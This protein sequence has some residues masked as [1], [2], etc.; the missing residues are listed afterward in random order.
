MADDVQRFQNP[1]S[2]FEIQRK[3]YCIFG[4]ER[5]F[6]SKSPE[7]FSAVFKQVGLR[8][9][10]VPFMSRPEKIADAVASIRA[11]NIAGVN[12]TVPHKESVIPHI[13]ILSEGAKII[14]A[15][16]TIAWDGDALK[17]YNTNAI[18]FMD[19]LEE[20]G[21]EVPGKRALVF[22][23]GG[24][25]RAVVF[26]LNWLRAEAVYIA[27]RNEVR[28]MDMAERLG[29]EAVALE[30][31]RAGPV[32]VD[33]IINATSVSAEDESPEFAALVGGLTL[34]GCDLLLDLNY[35]R[36]VN[37][38]EQ[39]AAASGVRFMDG[40]RP[41]AYQARRTFALWTGVQV[42]PNEFLTV[43]EVGG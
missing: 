31:V 25:A 1:K 20:I 35:G 16:N 33:L 26:I 23:S 3:V 9:V 12:V 28:A 29:G 5:V 36:E 24:A 4:D 13:D 37:I 11:L 18:G 8:C 41:L 30:D 34:E 27:A 21:W 2:A 39:K 42:E 6:N 22:G 43:L 19:T 14:G 15:V 32:D 38:W 7:M 17:G 40:L 10:Y